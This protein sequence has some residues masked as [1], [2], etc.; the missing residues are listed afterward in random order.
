MLGGHTTC[1]P[2][3]KACSVTGAHFPLCGATTFAI[4]VPSSDIVFTARYIGTLIWDNETNLDSILVDLHL[5]Y[6]YE[7][8][9]HRDIKSEKLICVE[10][11]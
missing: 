8:K 3:K 6:T 2:G 10:L 5:I 1:T 11:I 4:R 7:R 9:K